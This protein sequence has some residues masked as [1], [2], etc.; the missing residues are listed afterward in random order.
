M[1]MMDGVIALELLGILIVLII[2][3]HGL[4]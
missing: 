1:K 4:N 2:F 3:G